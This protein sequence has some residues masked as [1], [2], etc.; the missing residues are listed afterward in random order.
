[1]PFLAR[2][3]KANKKKKKQKCA[4]KL[5]SFF[6]F[7]FSG[8][9]NLNKVKFV[10]DPKEFASLAALPQYRGAKILHEDLVMVTMREKKCFFSRPYHIGFSILELAKYQVRLLKSCCVK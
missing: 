7:F 9:R 10:K 4:K 1:M 6:F 3:F 8:A 5:K 2:P